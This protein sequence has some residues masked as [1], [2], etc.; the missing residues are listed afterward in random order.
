VSSNRYQLVIRDS[1]LCSKDNLLDVYVFQE[2]VDPN[3][4]HTNMDLMDNIFF[5]NS[6]NELKSIDLE[7]KDSSNFFM[8]A[9]LNFI[10]IILI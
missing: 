6:R 8:K 4:W 10:M 3:L 5:L 7:N 2:F 1:S 9:N